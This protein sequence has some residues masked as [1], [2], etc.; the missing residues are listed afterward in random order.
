M[1]FIKFKFEGDETIC[2]ILFGE[3]TGYIVIV[4]RIQVWYHSTKRIS[5]LVFEHHVS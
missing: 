1:K 2:F 3:G 5:V 4:V